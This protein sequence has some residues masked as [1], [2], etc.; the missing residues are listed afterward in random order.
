[1]TRR[2]LSSGLLL[3]ALALGSMGCETL[4]SMLRSKKNDEELARKDAAEGLNPT[5]VESDTSKIPAV[6]S[7]DKNQKPFFRNS[8]RPGGWS[9]EAR[10]I[11][12]GLGYY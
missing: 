3:G 5:A 7:D 1:M 9:S 2:F 8:G 12:R 6:D 10:E 4:H 11:E